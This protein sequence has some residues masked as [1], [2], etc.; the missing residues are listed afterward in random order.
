MHF[1]AN[2][3]FL[4]F[5]VLDLSYLFHKM[6]KIYSILMAFTLDRDGAATRL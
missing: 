4:L 3:N 5:S 2:A 1:F 6:L